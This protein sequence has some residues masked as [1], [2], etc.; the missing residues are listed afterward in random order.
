MPEI[1]TNGRRLAWREAGSGAP[2]LLLHCT[3]A[4]SG[5]WSGVMARLSDRL[6]MRAPDLPGHG[7]TDFD[8]DRLPQAQALADALALPPADRPAHVIGHSFGG[9][10]A[11]RLAVEAPERVASLTL[12]DPV[13]FALLAETDPEAYAAEMAQADP[14]RA[15]MAAGDWEGAADAFL[16]RWGTG[17]PPT[18]TQRAAMVAGM[19]FVWRSEPEIAL[20]ETATIKAASLR[21]ITVPT[22]VITGAAS[23]PS[24]GA[25][26]EGLAQVMPDVRRV[27]IPGA[28]HMV[29][30]THPAEVSAAIRDFLFPD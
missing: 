24:I 29:P 14:A 16:A 21:R 25:I 28:G 19:P 18:P 23:P 2:A 6:A 8:P 3:L 4:H 9:T 7:R 27:E 20:P 22:L 10:V 1:V 13:L 12:V 15:C 11:L 5:A 17:A 30:I 26:A